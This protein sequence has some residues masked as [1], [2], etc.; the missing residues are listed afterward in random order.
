MEVLYGLHPVEEAIRSGS[1]QLDHVSVSRERRDERLER[2]VQLR[3]TPGPPRSPGPPHQPTPPPPTR[4]PPG[5][6]AAVPYPSL[7]RPGLTT[8]VRPRPRPRRRPPPR[9]G[10]EDLR[11]PPPDSHGRPVLFAQPIRSRSH[12]HVR[13]R[14]P[15]PQARRVEGTSSKTPQ[16]PWIVKNMHHSLSLLAVA[17]SLGSTAIAQVAQPT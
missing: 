4:P 11:P 13:S 16:G 6:P 12:R 10:Q 8:R 5:P 9:S 1:R 14:A 2:P 15:T 7:H 17:L 3:R